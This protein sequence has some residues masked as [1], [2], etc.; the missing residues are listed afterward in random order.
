MITRILGSSGIEVSGLGLG[1]WAIGGPDSNLGLP[2]GWG[3][4]DDATAVAGLE[5]AW[6]LG[7]RLFD[8]ADVYGHGRSERLLGRLVAQVPRGQLRLVSKVGYFTGTAAHGYDT[9]HMRR[10]LDQTLDNLG[11]EH[12]DIYFFHHS[13]FGRHNE[14]RVIA[15]WNPTPAVEPTRVTRGC[16]S[17]NWRS[18]IQPRNSR[19]ALTVFSP[20]SLLGQTYS[21]RSTV[22]GGYRGAGRPMYCCGRDRGEVAAGRG[23]CPYPVGCGTGWPGDEDL[24]RWGLSGPGAG[25]GS[26]AAMADVMGCS[27][28]RTVSST[29]ACQSNGLCRSFREIC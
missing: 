1:C 8:T 10:Q 20:K 13:E 19:A 4:I 21:E 22:Y 2:M 6:E 11:T 9:G 5:Q 26:V 29:V 7:V 3:L 24:R 15:C 18:P 17:R 25:A 23:H 28:G 27:I 16:H 12:V 14:P